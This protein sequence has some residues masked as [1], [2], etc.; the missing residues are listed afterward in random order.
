MT[1]Q[2]V[3]RSCVW[4]H[5]HASPHAK[6]IFMQTNPHSPTS[7]MSVI[8]RPPFYVTATIETLVSTWNTRTLMLDCAA[9]RS[10]SSG[11]WLTV[12]RKA[13]TMLHTRH[14]FAAGP[15]YIID[16]LANATTDDDWERILH[17]TMHMDA[18]IHYVDMMHCG[19][20]RTE[21]DAEQVLHQ[22]QINA[23]LR[24]CPVSIN[25]PPHSADVLVMRAMLL[26]AMPGHLVRHMS[27]T[28]FVIHHGKLQKRP[29]NGVI[30]IDSRHLAQHLQLS[31]HC[32][33]NFA[34][35][36]ELTAVLAAP[37]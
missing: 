27:A 28:G 35:W 20:V 10:L 37:K 16:A 19:V 4:E 1:D 29:D 15:S 11:T 33:E 8:I 9:T 36:R 23:M 31:H 7:G 26:D 2:H 17:D 25:T 18:T 14:S 24:Q 13:P 34:Q 6:A 32:G 22:A 21:T 12:Y 30:A 5:V 3:G